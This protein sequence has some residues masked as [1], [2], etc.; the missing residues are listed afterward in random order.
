MNQNEK[1]G[2]ETV[3]NKILLKHMIFAYHYWNVLGFKGLKKT[4]KKTRQRTEGQI[5][6]RKTV[7]VTKFFVSIR[8]VLQK[9]QQKNFCNKQIK[10]K[11]REN[12]LPCVL[13]LAY[14]VNF[15]CTVLFFLGLL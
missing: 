12:Q 10:A 8:S 2:P 13:A 14:R 6:G 9:Q 3:F 7:S 15:S 5:K 4:K 1:S 11:K